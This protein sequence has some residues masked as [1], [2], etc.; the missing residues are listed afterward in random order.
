MNFKILLV[1]MFLLEMT[2]FAE[3]YYQVS[4]N[5]QLESYAKWSVE[6]VK[7]QINSSENQVKLSYQ[8]PK[9]LVG[10]NIDLFFSGEYTNE[11]QLFLSGNQGTAICVVKQRNIVSCETRLKLNIDLNLVES[12][13]NSLEI[14]NDEYQGR[15]SVAENFKHDPVGELVFS[16]NN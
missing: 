2:V 12:H 14:E 13:L 16:T 7:W 10:T 5:D 1:T 3:N 11:N 15:L 6:Q 4:A 8:L 9:K